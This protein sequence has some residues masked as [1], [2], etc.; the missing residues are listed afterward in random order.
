MATYNNPKVTKLEIDTDSGLTG[1]IS[2]TDLDQDST[3]LEVT[4]PDGPTDP[5]GNKYKTVN[6][7]EG[8][9]GVKDMDFLY[10][11]TMNSGNTLET[12]IY[13]NTDLYFRVTCEDGTIDGGIIGPYR[14]DI[15]D[16]TDFS[17]DE[18]LETKV[19]QLFSN[20][21]SADHRIQ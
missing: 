20:K 12:E 16:P 7:L 9:V 1:A 14:L 6:R 21:Y 18:D 15:T 4:T 19:V 11:D 10:T 5:G 2:T 17:S 13:S 3:D 8:G